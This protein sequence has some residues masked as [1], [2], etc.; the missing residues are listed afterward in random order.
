MKNDINGLINNYI[1]TSNVGLQYY[2]LLNIYNNDKSNT[3]I[4]FL[5]V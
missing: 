1:N 3:N 4:L 5:L 2:N